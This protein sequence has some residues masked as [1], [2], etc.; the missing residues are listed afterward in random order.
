MKDFAQ[1]KAGILNNNRLK[2]SAKQ[3][4]LIKLSEE[5]ISELEAEK[6][7]NAIR[8]QNVTEQ[9]DNLKKSKYQRP[10]PSVKINT[11]KLYDDSDKITSGLLGNIVALMAEQRASE[12]LLA[13]LTMTK[14]FEM[15]T[16]VLD[17][18]IFDNPAA[19]IRSWPSIVKDSERFAGNVGMAAQIDGLYTKA[20]ENEKDAK[21]KKWEE[22]NTLE[23]DAL[24]QRKTANF[25]ETLQ[26]GIELE[27]VR[28]EVGSMNA[29]AFYDGNSS[30]KLTPIQKG[31]LEY[32]GDVD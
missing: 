32:F 27:R 6:E 2:A 12:R 19:L 17:S 8:Q 14:D 3:E 26:L 16:R 30:A 9:L 18:A 1:R 29:Q 28:G 7:A 10:L 15:Y 22:K 20:L 13:Q 24:E 23:L 21:E 11:E 25:T 4:D 5:H 31:Q